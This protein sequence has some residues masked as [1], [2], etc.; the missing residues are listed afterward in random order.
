MD[1][2]TALNMSTLSDDDRPILDPS[3]NIDKLEMP[4]GQVA[5]ILI[6]LSW[7]L[8]PQVGPRL[9]WEVKH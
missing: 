4:Y 3:I 6:Q 5:D 9:T 8:L 1:L 7:L 2:R